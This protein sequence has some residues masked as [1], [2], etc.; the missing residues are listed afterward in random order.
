MNLALTILI[1]NCLFIY[2]TCTDSKHNNTK[3]S[4]HNVTEPLG[5][6][7]DSNLSQSFR[8]VDV[9]QTQSQMMSKQIKGCVNNCKAEYR[10]CRKRK[11]YA[12]LQWKGAKVKFQSCAA[13]KKECLGGCY[14]FTKSEII[15]VPS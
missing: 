8:Q 4:E 1:L 6:G 10:L 11:E 3:G 15:S 7:N 14:K 5:G 2:S 12:Q 9:P 13:I